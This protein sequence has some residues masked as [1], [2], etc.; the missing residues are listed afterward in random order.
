MKTTI[1]DWIRW[2]ERDPEMGKMI[3]LGAVLIPMWLVM[4]LTLIICDIR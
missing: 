4:F 1:S 3:A 2:M